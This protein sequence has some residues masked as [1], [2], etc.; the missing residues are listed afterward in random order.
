MMK[1][2]WWR[3]RP[4]TVI[5]HA[6]VTFYAVSISQRTNTGMS[7]QTFPAVTH[8]GLTEVTYCPLMEETKGWEKKTL[9]VFSP[10]IYMYITNKNNN[11]IYAFVT[12]S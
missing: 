2:S 9:H 10:H 6:T 8:P 1:K 12:K 7:A 11:A 4:P 3:G 5:P